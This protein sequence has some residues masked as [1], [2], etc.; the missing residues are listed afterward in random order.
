MHFQVARGNQGRSDW[1][2]ELGAEKESGEQREVEHRFLVHTVASV[3]SG[4]VPL[5]RVI[6]LCSNA[7][8]R[9]RLSQPPPSSPTQ[10][11]AMATPTVAEVFDELATKFD[12]EPPVRTW[13]TAQDGLGATKLDDFI[14]AASSPADISKMIEA[15]KPSNK[16]LQTSR[17]RQAWEACGQAKK[18]EAELVKKG[19]DESDLDKLLEQ[20][21]LDDLAARF[22]S[23]YKMAYPPEIAPS[24]LMIS[25]ISRELDKRLSSV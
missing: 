9:S 13:L 23:R 8:G 21:V 14:F 20:P 6:V 3:G 4:G 16:F 22:W 15:A 1:Q 11:A 2:P 7:C 10:P 19:L 12:L 24:D 5:D 25:R 17:L 18:D